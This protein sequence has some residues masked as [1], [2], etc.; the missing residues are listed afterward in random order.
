VSDTPLGLVHV[1][2]ATAADEATLTAL[3][4]RLTAFDL[5]PWRRPEDI[6]TADAREMMAAVRAADSDN[7]VLIA[8]R[9]G[10]AVGCLHIL[11]TADFFGTRHAH[12]SVIA[13]SLEA[14]GTGV[15]RVLMAEAESWA[16]RRRL[17]LL[18]LNVFASNSRAQRLYERSGFA[19]EFLKYT[20]Q[21]PT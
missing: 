6:A 5:P 12:I 19:P 8:E 4:W 3:A 20:K 9:D 14:E 15:G 18:T 2:A 16:L 13:T 21:L 1:R 7:E 17:P 10:S 11:A